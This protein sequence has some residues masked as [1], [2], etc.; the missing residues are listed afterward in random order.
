MYQHQWS[1]ESSDITKLNYCKFEKYQVVY[2]SKSTPNISPACLNLFLE[3]LCH[4]KET[5]FKNYFLYFF[6]VLLLKRLYL[7]IIVALTL[8]EQLALITPAQIKRSDNC[9]LTLSICHH[10]KNA[11]H[12]S[13]SILLNITKKITTADVG[14]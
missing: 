2:S 12:F 4:P 9:L 11:V 3:V 13:T 1:T 8:K 14:K 7:F 6:P 5:F 10:T